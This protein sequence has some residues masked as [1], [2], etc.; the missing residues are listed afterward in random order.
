M[1]CLCQQMPPFEKNFLGYQDAL[2]Q[3][4]KL[5][6]IWEDTKDGGGVHQKGRFG[7]VFELGLAFLHGSDVTGLQVQKICSLSRH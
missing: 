3:H 5:P 4:A 7:A 2:Q 6:G 1:L